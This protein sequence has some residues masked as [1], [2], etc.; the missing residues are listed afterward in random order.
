MGIDDA[1]AAILNYF[2]RH[3]EA[4]D[5]LDGIARWRLAEERAHRVVEE[6]S[7]ALDWLVKE[8]LL[9]ESAIPGGGKVYSLNAHKVEEA[10]KLIATKQQD[11]AED[12]RPRS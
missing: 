12:P 11:R 8:E 1:A 3:P 9:E 4:A 10:R 6:T 2:I 5:D 7:R